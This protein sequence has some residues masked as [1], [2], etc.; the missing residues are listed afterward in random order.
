MLGPLRVK[1]LIA[2][3]LRGGA[4]S[5]KYQTNWAP[6]PIRPLLLSAQIAH[7]LKATLF[8]I[9]IALCLHYCKQVFMNV[10]LYVQFEER[11]DPHKTCHH[12]A[13][14]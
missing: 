6:M 1:I 7:T 3:K 2:K 5:F 11:L 9:R 4:T 8:P 10:A 14:K 12:V 13:K